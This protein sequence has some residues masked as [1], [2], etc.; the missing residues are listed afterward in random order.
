MPSLVPRLTPTLK[1]KGKGRPGRFSHM[2]G[3]MSTWEL[4]VG[5]YDRVGE[6]ASGVPSHSQ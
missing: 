1:Q 6:S 4:K 5:E 2:H 3:V